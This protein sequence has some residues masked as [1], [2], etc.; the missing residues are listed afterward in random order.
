M[1]LAEGISRFGSLLTLT[2][3]RAGGDIAG[4]LG[5]LTQLRWLGVMDVAEENARKLYASIMEMQGL[6]SLSLEA[7]YTFDQGQLVLWD[8][9]SP[10][11]LLQKLWLEGPLEKI[12]NWPGS[13]NSLTKPGLGSWGKTS[14][15]LVPKLEVLIIAFHVLEEW[16]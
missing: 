4:E 3:V 15:R 16:T 10:P 8:S 12:P 6:L 14:A 11:P 1:K 2:G 5:K 7:K 13:I 9:L